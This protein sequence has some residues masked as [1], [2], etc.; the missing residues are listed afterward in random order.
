MLQQHGLGARPYDCSHCSLKFFFRIEL[1]QHMVTAHR[2]IE[3]SSSPV[4]V[5]QETTTENRNKDSDSRSVNVTVKEE[6]MNS[7]EDEEVNVDG[8]PENSEAQTKHVERNLVDA[9]NEPFAVPQAD[10]NIESWSQR[11]SRIAH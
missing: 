1:D 6:V 10:E 4:D 7:I 2:G 8:N 3:S 5:G 9:K 11:T